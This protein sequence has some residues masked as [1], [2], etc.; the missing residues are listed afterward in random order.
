[1]KSNSIFAL[2]ALTAAWSSTVDAAER[3][4]VQDGAARAEIIIAA[5]PQ[6]TV[7]LAAHELQ[8]YV[9]KISGA[10]L[11]IAT[12]PTA[13]VPVQVYIGRSPHTDRLQVTAE[14][15][16]A[17][18]YRI[19]SGE[20]W[21]VL[22][23][24]DTEFVPIEP[25]A[26][27]NS[28]I[29]TGKT[30]REWDEITGA[31]WGVPG[32]LMYKHQLDL[33]GTV[34]LPTAQPVAVTSPGTKVPP[35]RMWDYDER[36][37]FN[38]V[39]GLLHRLGVRWYM[40]GELGEIVPT[41]QSIPLPK[42]DETVRPDIAMRRFSYRFSIV[43]LENALWGM[44]LGVRNPPDIQDVHGM[45]S[46]T[47]RTEVFAAHP[48]WYALYGGKRS[49]DLKANNHLCYSNEELLQETVR[50][51]RAQFDHYKL[52]TVSVMPPD[53]YSAMCQC[54]KC[55]GKDTP[56]RD[57]RGILSDYVWDFVNRVARETRKTHPHGKVLNCAYGIYSL[58]PLKIEKLE[59]NVVV[60]IVGGRVPGL[61]K[62][63]QQAEFRK[64]RESWLE[65]TA[66][67]LIN[68]ENYPFIDRGWYLPTFTPH[69]M[70]ESINAV[71][72]RFSGEDISLS[73]FHDF[74]VNGIGFNHFQMYF[75][76]RMY[77]GGKEQDVDAMFR[78]Y[79]RL[80]YGPAED[81]MRAFFEY[82]EA[83]WQEMEKEKPKVDHVLELFAA[84]KAKVEPSSV[85]G[86]RIALIDEFLKALRSK[87]RQLGKIRGPVPV[88]RL[89]GEARNPI[90]ID[91]KL[92]DDAWVN[93]PIAATGRMSE[94]QT[95]RVPTFG[96]SVKSAWIGNDLYFAIRCDEKKGEQLNIGSTRKD[97]S[98]T[99]Y[100]DV[101]EIL[102]ET[103][104]RSYYQIAVNPS[105]AI[106]DLD[107]TTAPSAWF[108]WDSQA[109][110]KTHI[111]DDHWTVEI[112]IPVT[113]DENDPLHQVIGRKPSQSL[114][115]HIN[116]CRQRIRDG[117]S[118]YS[119]FSPTSAENFH[120]RMKFATFYDGNSYPFAASAPDAD[121]LHAFRTA[122]DFA[123]RGKHAEALAAYRAAAVGEISDVQKSAAL[124][125]AAGSARLLRNHE[126]AAELAAAVPIDAVKK[127]VVMQNLLDRFKAPEVVAEFGK[128][129]IAGWPFWKIA[130][131]FFTRGRA[132]S[133]VKSGKEAEADFTR[134]L[135][136]TGDSRTRDAVGYALG[137]N[138]EVNLKDDDGALA[139]YRGVFDSA[140]RLG[141]SD[142]F[143][144]VEAAARILT[145]RGKF[146][147][148]LA[149]L[150]KVDVDKLQGYWRG[151]MLLALG[152]TLRAAGRND[153][154]TRAFRSVIDDASL[155][156]RLRKTA[157]EKLVPNPPTNRKTP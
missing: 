2:L 14:G 65:K 90:K 144:A 24:D 106:V 96:T 62:A 103:D 143:S 83:N 57:Q 108:G 17:G 142:Q 132:Y 43:G 40:P 71:K 145:R 88:L 50:Y 133:I 54:P 48:E 119:A 126:L 46:L 116:L 26:K 52:D 114:P 95:G 153:E 18:A 12:E 121:F 59:P 61:N 22:I 156:V 73:A 98:A 63:A 115:W 105:G 64:L 1:M 122:D 77:W 131:G 10:K 87:S 138:R 67:P 120:N 112:R 41:L 91:G 23:G 56:E 125:K 37:S 111:A 124:E 82:A 109:E 123:R 117:G 35:L 149:T 45:V 11:P 58:P 13:G 25:W 78:E 127:T 31:L 152:D 97:D 30:Q 130:D 146:D 32:I 128:E 70:G 38:A 36:G 28:D 66:N 139:A 69:A 148:A 49:F 140:V 150:R 157:E 42:I 74:A 76:A 3:F 113:Q 135:E 9:E 72:G 5:K 99:W 75:N 80:F 51:V 101:V 6:R 141:S 7:R 151:T 154:A 129:E 19:A 137:D 8:T 4:L 86:R 89:V 84:A 21:L 27:S 107:R 60:S 155:D 34:G 79:C 33:P 68:F 134:A 15:L 93:A 29:V 136:W 100:G 47:H 110:V 104:S 118:E 39:N 92:D 81:E 55:A 147:D 94:L 102:L 44:R 53:G 85:Y 16:E 20:D